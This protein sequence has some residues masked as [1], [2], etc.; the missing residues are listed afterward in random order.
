MQ[1]R[2]RHNTPEDVA[3]TSRPDTLNTHTWW[4]LQHDTV[5]A[6]RLVVN[7]GELPPGTAHQLHRHPN[8]EQALVVL[9]GRGI[10]LLSD[11]PP[12]PVETGDTVFVPAGEWH[13]FANP[14]A[15]T[16][17]IANIYGG[18]GTREDA[19]YELHPGEPFDLASY[20]QSDR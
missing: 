15:T 13:G 3:A 18:V 10:Q 5:G 16:V 9:S 1:I 20:W 17:T 2:S 8:A 19:G 11:A 4:L 6:Q 14:F 7:I 12:V